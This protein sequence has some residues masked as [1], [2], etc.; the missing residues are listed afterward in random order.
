ML[1][2]V[3]P[4]RLVES[5]EQMARD[6]EHPDFLEG[7][8]RHLLRLVGA[9]NGGVFVGKVEPIVC[10]LLP[11]GERGRRHRDNCGGPTAN[12]Q[13]HRRQDLEQ[14]G[15]LPRPRIVCQ[16]HILRPTH[17][18][19]RTRLSLVLVRKQSLTA[20]VRLGKDAGDVALASRVQTLLQSPRVPRRLGLPLRKH[21]LFA[22]LL[23]LLI[24]LLQFALW[25]L[26]GISIVCIACTYG[27][28]LAKCYRSPR[29]G[30]GSTL[31]RSQFRAR[32]P[33]RRGRHGRSHTVA[34]IKGRHSCAVSEGSLFHPV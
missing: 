13:L 30:S 12:A 5:R 22:F 25:L 14:G 19:H 26:V 18:R 10:G 1:L 32:R 20:H 4:A 28:S 7:A 29:K 3:L 17:T 24:V 8:L 34:R 16:N 6:H 11:L 23:N 33:A 27:R 9:Q 21:I 15:R 31:R 2:D